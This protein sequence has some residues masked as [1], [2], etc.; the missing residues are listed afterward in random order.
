VI[1]EK[2]KLHYLLEAAAAERPDNIAVADPDRDGSVSYADLNRLAD[3]LCRKLRNYGVADSDRVGICAPKSIGT[4]IALYGILKSDA[5][6]V[7]VDCSA[8]SAR[9]AFVFGNCAVKALIV[10]NS[11]LADLRA[12]YGQGSLSVIDNLPELAAFSEELV[13]VEGPPVEGES[14]QESPPDLAYI[15]YTSGS[16]GDPKGVMLSHGNALSFIDWIAD[17]FGMNEHDRFS[18]H[19]PFHFDLSILDLFA[20]VRHMATLVLIGEHLGK[21]PVK[22]A[23]IIADQKLSVWYSTPSI[24]RLLVEFG[25]MRP[26][27]YASLRI[28]FF[29][30]EVFPVKHFRA[31]REIW[32]GPKYYNL[33]GPTETNVCTYYKVPDEFQETRNETFPIGKVCSDDQGRVVDESGR[34]VAFGAEGELVIYGGSVMQGYWNLPERN[35]LS[36]IEDAAGVR[37]YRTGDIVREEEEGY[38]YISRRDRMVKRKGYRVELGEIEVALYK[39]EFISEAAVVAVPDEE[40]GVIIRAFLNWSGEGKPSLIQL[41]QFCAANLQIYMVPDYFSILPELPKTSTDKIDY[42]KLKGMN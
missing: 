12:E 32:T 8:P 40:S 15:L 38:I 9:N 1:G 28:V 16:T 29:A 37:W 39:H 36:F 5:A 25:R 3:S 22:L 33:Y 23:E 24:L 19:A 18:S 34:E 35:K 13:L 30:G 31:L 41:K 26:E 6:Y 4:V 20:P 11:L 2:R 7:P 14:A 27:R 42:Q 17:T 21:Q 10:D